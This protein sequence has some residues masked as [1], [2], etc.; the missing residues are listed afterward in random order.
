MNEILAD[1][2]LEYQKYLENP[3]RNGLIYGSSAMRGR[4]RLDAVCAGG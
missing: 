4:V 1:K 3:E 2:Q